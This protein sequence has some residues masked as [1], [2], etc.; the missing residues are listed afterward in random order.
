MT[1]V[2]EVVLPSPAAL[3]AGEVTVDCNHK[4]IEGAMT[5]TVLSNELRRDEGSTAAPTSKQGREAR[6]EE[7]DT[8]IPMSIS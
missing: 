5:F 7:G 3:R 2:D 6:E 8:H 4:A 1:E